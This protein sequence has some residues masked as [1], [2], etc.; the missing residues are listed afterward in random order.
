MNIEEKIRDCEY[1]LNQNNH[2]NPDPY[3]VNYFFKAYLQSVI[4]FYD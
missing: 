4:D 3:Y 1:N 2:F